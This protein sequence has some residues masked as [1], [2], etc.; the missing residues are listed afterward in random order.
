MF[1]GDLHFSRFSMRALACLLT[2]A[3]G[4]L[5]GCSSPSGSES[6]SSPGEEAS[7]QTVPSSTLD[8]W[9]TAVCRPG[10][11]INGTVGILRN[12]DGTATCKSLIGDSPVMMGQYSSAFS[13][14]ND[15]AV[16]KGSDYATILMES[17]S[18]QLFLAYGSRVS[19]PNPLQPLTQFGFEVGSVP[20][21]YD[22]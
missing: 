11:Y 19:R 2:A 21:Q 22:R 13:L 7:S 20:F 3:A 4:V 5:A 10:T 14:Q 17:G 6:A 1:A 12:A 18:T 15:I 16:H 8:D 9:L